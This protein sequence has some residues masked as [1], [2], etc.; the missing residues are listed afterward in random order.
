MHAP[1]PCNW[2]IKVF[3][4][5]CIKVTY[6]NFHIMCSNSLIQVINFVVKGILNWLVLF[7][8]GACVGNYCK[9]INFPPILNKHVLLS[10]A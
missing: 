5:F 7:F 1:F 4:Y 9:V 6:C 10:M 2:L 3:S 8:C